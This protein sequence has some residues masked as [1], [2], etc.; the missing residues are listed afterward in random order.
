MQRIDIAKLVGRARR[1][2]PRHKRESG[3]PRPAMLACG[4]KIQL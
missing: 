2:R 3:N 1:S 4:L